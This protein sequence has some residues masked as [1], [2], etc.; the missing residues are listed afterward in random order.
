MVKIKKNVITMTR[1][2]SL[3]AKITITDASGD[4]YIPD[5][6]DSIR[7]ALK[8]SFHDAEP[9]IVK[10]IPFDTLVLQLD[11]E[12]T[13]PLDIGEYRY[14]IEITLSNGVVDTFIPWAKFILTEEV[15]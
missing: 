8:Q 13:K 6:N 4:E 12:D 11:P 1:G 5:E 9:L 14:D 10:A 3:I 2:D 7:F 15:I